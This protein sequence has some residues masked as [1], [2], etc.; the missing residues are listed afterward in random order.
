MHRLM[1]M[2]LVVF[3]LLFAAQAQAST[4]SWEEKRFFETA[5]RAF[6]WKCPEVKKLVSGWPWDMRSYGYQKG[7]WKGAGAREINCTNGATYYL[8]IANWSASLCY[9]ET[10]KEL[11]KP[12]TKDD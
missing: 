7:H 8:L 5:I 2:V 4:T 11:G 1:M 3:C 10:C 6:G 12:T 9:E